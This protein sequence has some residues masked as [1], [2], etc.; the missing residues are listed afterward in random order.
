[1]LSECWVV[2]SCEN[3]GETLQK[4]TQTVE[5]GVL[6]AGHDSISTQSVT[7]KISTQRWIHSD[8][9]SVDN[10]LI[11]LT[12]NP[13]CRDSMLVYQLNNVH[14][15][16]T[17]T[18]HAFAIALHHVWNKLPPTFTNASSSMVTYKSCLRQKCFSIHLV[19]RIISFSFLP[20][21]VTRSSSHMFV[22]CRFNFLNL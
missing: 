3:A 7:M 9:V 20:D 18:L 10:T 5:I 17:H 6:T 13:T 22:K 15:V 8:R 19:Y 12:V 2:F 1:M 16:N 4:H 21:C 14:P 11:S